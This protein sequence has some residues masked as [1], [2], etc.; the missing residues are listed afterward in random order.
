MLKKRLIPVL[1]LQ[2]GLIVRSEGFHQ[3]KI[4]GNPLD[5]LERLSEWEADE[6][7]YVDITRSGSHESLRDDLKKQMDSS[8]LGILK[9][10]SKKATMPLTFGGRITELSQVDETIAHGADKVLINTQAYLKP[11]LIT[12]VAKKYGS[13]AMMVGIDIKKVEG[14]HRIF[15]HQGREALQDISPLDWAR[16]AVEAGAGEILVNSIDRDG[17]A[18]GYDL[19]IMEALAQSLPVPV[20]ACGGAGVF[21]HFKPV[22]SGAVAAAAAGNIFH[23]TELAYRRAKK[24]LKSQGIAVR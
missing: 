17:T 9:E 2:N 8:L 14:E 7:V 22:L 20:I 19:E 21:E 6:L 23:F 15:I 1:Y 13:Q 12:Q 18:E 11:S 3:F 24:Y 16:R 4:I 5:Q 10:I